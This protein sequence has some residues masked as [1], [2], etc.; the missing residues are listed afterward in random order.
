MIDHPPQTSIPDRWEEIGPA[1]VTNA[2]AE[3]HPQAEVGEVTVLMREDGTNRRLRLGVKYTKG[4]GPE[5]LFLKANEPA[6]RSVHLRN[7]NLFNEAQL[8]GSR[9]PLMVDHPIVY[10]ALLDKEKGNFLLVMEDVTKRGGDPRDA[11]RPLSI[12]E[13]SCGI[14]SLARMHSEYWCFTS[15]THPRLDWVQTW[16]ATE[17]WKQG[18]RK[19]IPIGLQRA[20]D[21]LPKAVANYDAEEIVDLWSRYVDSLTMRPVTLLHADAHIGNTYVLPDGNVGFLDWQVVRRGEWSQDVGY[22]LVSAL[23]SEDRRRSE[24]DLLEV[25]R[26]A[27]DVPDSDRLSREQMWLRYRTTPAYG[28]AIWLSTLGTDGFQSQ[29]VSSELAQRFSSAFVELDTLAAL[30]DA[31]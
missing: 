23:T 31:A 9:V 29:S 12:E 24:R 15:A 3:R 8:L 11:T 21:M 28:M 17:G 2:I 13:V 6:H 19:C 14:R 22:F 4:S 20:G 18:L 7:G 1:W 25:Y 27:L 16:A 5:T 10:Q 26:T 30:A